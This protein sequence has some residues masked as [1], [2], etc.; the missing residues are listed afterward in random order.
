[1]KAHGGRG[2]WRQDSYSEKRLEGFC[3]YWHQGLRARVLWAHSLL[4]NLK[5]QRKSENLTYEK[6]QKQKQKQTDKQNK[7][8]TLYKSTKISKTE[9]RG[10]G[11]LTFYL[12]LCLAVCLWESLCG[13][14]CS[15]EI[16]VILKWRLC[17]QSWDWYLHSKKKSHC[18][19][20]V[21]HLEGHGHADVNTLAVLSVL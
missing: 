2:N 1:M 20:L 10:D 13:S 5:P 14:W 12:V 15:F 3:F 6:K 4:V 9:K 19:G 18:P 11:R 16:D 7:W 8:A 17:S 21:T